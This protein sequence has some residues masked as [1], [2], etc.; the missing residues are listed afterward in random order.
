MCQYAP[1]S[2]FPPLPLKDNLGVE[3]ISTVA[4][5]TKTETRLTPAGED[6]HHGRLAGD[7]N[8]GLN[9]TELTRAKL[10]WQ[11]GTAGNQVRFGIAVA[12]YVAGY[13]QPYSLASGS[14][15]GL[16]VTCQDSSAPDLSIAV[17]L[18]YLLTGPVVAYILGA[19]IEAGQLVV[20]GLNVRVAPR[21]PIP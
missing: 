12:P 16:L 3:P 13:G 15:E 18:G 19:W 1:L 2:R 14:G 7:P 11:V 9:Y 10:V 17:P 4:F 6:A 8:N 20:Q 21:T 5:L